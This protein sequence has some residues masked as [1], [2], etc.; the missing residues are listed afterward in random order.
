MHLPPETKQE[1]V[2]QMLADDSDVFVAKA[3]AEVV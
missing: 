3:A 2:R 1:M